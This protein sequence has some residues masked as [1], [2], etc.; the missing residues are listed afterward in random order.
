M[1]LQDIYSTISLLLSN[2]AL[3]PDKLSN[4]LLNV[5]NIEKKTSKGYTP[6]YL[7]LP[8]V[9]LLLTFLFRDNSYGTKE[10]KQD[11]IRS[12]PS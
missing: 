10:T 6:N 3:G 4:K 8:D 1:S 9:T 11:T 2:K 5:Y 12:K 7:S